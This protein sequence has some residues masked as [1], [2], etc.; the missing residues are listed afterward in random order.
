MGFGVVFWGVGVGIRV[1]V[2]G[3]VTVWEGAVG[4]R[5]FCRKMMSAQQEN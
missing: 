1:V 2:G 4:G 5:R 3:V